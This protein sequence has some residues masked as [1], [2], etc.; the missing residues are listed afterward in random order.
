MVTMADLQTHSIVCAH[1]DPLEIYKSTDKLDKNGDPE[2]DLVDTLM[3]PIS[4]GKA[5][6]M[7]LPARFNHALLATSEGKGGGT[8][9]WIYTEP[10]VGVVTKTPFFGRCEPRYPIES[11]MVDYFKLRG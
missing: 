2:Q 6:R 10:R 8:R 9:R 11:G 4:I 1:Q 3:V 7:K 5:G